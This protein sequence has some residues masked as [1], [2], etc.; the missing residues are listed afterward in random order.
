MNYGCFQVVPFNG[1]NEMPVTYKARGEVLTT[2][3]QH[4]SPSMT[5][6]VN[7]H[8]NDDVV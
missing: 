4:G 1:V 7:Q 8:F 5:L 6:A 3:R 2:V